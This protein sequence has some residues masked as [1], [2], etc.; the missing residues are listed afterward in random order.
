M[1][2]LIQN[3]HVVFATKMS[4]RIK[5]QSFVLYIKNGSIENA[6]ALQLGNM[7]HLYL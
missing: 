5:K 2:N 3:N 6:M 1:H 4:T 7:K